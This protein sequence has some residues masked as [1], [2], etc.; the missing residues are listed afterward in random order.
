MTYVMRVALSMHLVDERETTFLA[1][2]QLLFRRWS[3]N[4]RAHL[5]RKAVTDSTKLSR[6]K[7]I[8]VGDRKTT[9]TM[10]VDFAFQYS[11][12]TNTVE[13]SFAIPQYTGRRLASNWF[14][15]QNYSCYQQLWRK[16][17]ES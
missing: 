2:D 8:K 1:R 13:L 6:I 15:A 16:S 14:Y 11:D 5:N 3:K 4:L 7:E 17:G 12:S 9:K 10:E